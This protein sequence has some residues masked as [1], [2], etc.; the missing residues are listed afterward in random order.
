[1]EAC[2]RESQMSIDISR[3]NFLAG[4]G[5]AAAA[6]A[7]G[8]CGNAANSGKAADG[9]K[10]KLTFCLDYTP[11]TNQTSA[12]GGGGLKESLSPPGGEGCRG[13]APT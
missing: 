5:A 1:M 8:A 12:L 7:L 2:G 4:T 13:F 10:T 6:L 3:R 11:N 9:K